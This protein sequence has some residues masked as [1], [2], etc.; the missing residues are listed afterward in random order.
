MVNAPPPARATLAEFRH[1]VC[2]EKSKMARAG[3]GGTCWA[4]GGQR[5]RMA[6]AGEGAGAPNSEGRG[7]DPSNVGESP[8]CETLLDGEGKPRRSHRIPVLINKM[9]GART[10]KFC[11]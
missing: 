10:P 4:V 8:I 1:D 7:T 2:S 11:I 6:R 9:T 3:T 5:P